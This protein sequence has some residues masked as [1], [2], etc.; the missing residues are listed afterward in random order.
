MESRFLL[1]TGSMRS[2]TTLLSELLYST[3]YGEE[4]H[5]DVA[6]MGDKSDLLRKYIKSDF[7]GVE[8]GLAKSSI[9]EEIDKY[10]PVKGKKLVG[11]KQTDITL[12]EVNVLGS[13]FNHPQVIVLLRD[14]RDI[15]CSHVERTIDRITLVDA[16]GLLLRNLNYYFG[17]SNSLIKRVKYESLVAEPKT[18]IS[19]VLC[20]LDLDVERYDFSSIDNGR[21]ASNSS[22]NNSKGKF[23]LK[24]KGIS[25]DNIGRYK[26]HLSKE[27]DKLISTLFYDFLSKEG[28][29]TVYC[30]N[31]YELW[32]FWLEIAVKV[33][34]DDENYSIL[35]K[36]ASERIGIDSVEEIIREVSSLPKSYL[37][38]LKERNKSL[39]DSNGSLREQNQNLREQNQVL[40]GNNKELVVQV[41]TLKNS[42]KNNHGKIKLAMIARLNKFLTLFKN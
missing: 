25:Q 7:E 23:L 41:K 26:S 1:V 8:L 18:V 9:I 38:T 13:I 22:F 6:F 42:N 19:E 16:F 4:R 37:D 39:T 29:D 36:I 21:I 10:S 20:F 14:P 30:E 40:S 31:T 32:K 12:G 15:F 27:F 35:K 28:F 33:R 24:N 2:G 11:I 5:K 3:S 34:L 17:E